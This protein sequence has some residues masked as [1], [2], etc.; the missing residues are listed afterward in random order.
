VL[1]LAHDHH[2]RVGYNRAFKSPT[3]LDAYLDVAAAGAYGNHTG[4]VI[5]DASG[6]VVSKIP[7]LVPEENNTLEVGYKGDLGRRVFLDVVG[8]YSFYDHFISPLTLVALPSKGT[9]AS[10]PDGTP[11]F[12]GLPQQGTLI[13]YSN[14]GTAQVAGANVGFDA[15]LVRDRLLLTGS[16]SYI[17]L[18][19]FTT[20][21]PS[22]MA[23]PLNVPEW[24][25]RGALTMNDVGL[26]GSFVR[27]QGRFADRYVFQSGIW[28]ST[29]MFADGHVPARFVADL[30]L[31]YHFSDGVTVSA[32]IF[33][34]TNDHGI[35]VLGAPPGGIVA[36]AQL[37]YTWS[38]LDY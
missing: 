12:A 6:N 32:N 34:L 33:D 21:N 38:G 14:Y 37:A 23:L 9:F 16:A 4:F 30:V 7:A 35:D 24:T 13:T 11:T 1:T 17:H 26:R 10:L 29:K 25:A 15:W 19:S 27:L 22:Q 18:V 31:G 5:T 28:D 2:L 8:F 36:Y 20:G 3:L